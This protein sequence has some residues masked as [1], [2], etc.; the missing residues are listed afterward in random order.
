MKPL[1]AA[2]LVATILLSFAYPASNA[3]ACFRTSV[4][5]PTPLMG[6]HGEI[7]RTLEGAIFE[8][9]G[10][11]EYLYAYYPD[12]TI[13]PDRGRML[14]EGKTVGIRALG[15]PVPQ[16]NQQEPR[17]GTQPS[18]PA[19]PRGSRS[20]DAPIQV[21]LRISGCDYFVA[22]GPNGLYVLEWYGGYDPDK[23]DGIYG[24]IRSYGFK[25]VIYSNGREGRIYVDDY[26]LSGDSALER[27]KEQC[28]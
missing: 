9:V 10:S 18:V 22:D 19:R 6:N 20:N 24:D 2:R 17:R 11:Y 16:T 12:V 8:V 13:C 15:K 25:N 1:T 21:L 23:G 14:V 7:F 26:A 4:M 28:Q 3:Q 27:L 5:A